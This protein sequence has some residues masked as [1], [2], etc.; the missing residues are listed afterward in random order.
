M[1]TIPAVTGCDTVVTI[2]ITEDPYETNTIDV[3]HCPNDSVQVGGEWYIGPGTFTDTIAAV[4]GCD[5]IVTINVLVDPY[6]TNTVD[7]SYCPGDSVQVYGEWYSTPG[8]FM[9]TLPAVTGCDSG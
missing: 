3:S 7:A 6:E 5:T 4:T 8:I 9:D 1:D 2:D